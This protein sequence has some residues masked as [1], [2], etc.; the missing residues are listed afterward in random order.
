MKGV[1]TITLYRK[2]PK[3]EIGS[4][5]FVCAERQRVCQCR[6]GHEPHRS[7]LS[8]STSPSFFIQTLQR[9]TLWRLNFATAKSSALQSQRPLNSWGRAH[10]LGVIGWESELK[11]V[12]EVDGY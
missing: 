6:N 9:Q 1:G 3:M 8:S 7:R 12:Q 11:L 10:L 4:P 2:G 5:N